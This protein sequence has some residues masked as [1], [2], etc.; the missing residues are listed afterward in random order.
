MDTNLGV[1]NNIFLKK[2]I[3]NNFFFEFPDGYTSNFKI[4]LLSFTPANLNFNQNKIDFTWLR[5]KLR[6]FVYPFQSLEPSG[7]PNSCPTTFIY[8][9]FEI[10]IYVTKLIGQ[11]G[12][13]LH[14]DRLGHWTTGPLTKCVVNAS[15]KRCTFDEGKLQLFC[16]CHIVVTWTRQ[17]EIQSVSSRE[18][19]DT[20]S[21]RI[22]I[23][24][25]LLTPIACFPYISQCAQCVILPTKQVY[26]IPLGLII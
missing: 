10:Q 15:C 25:I 5:L 24:L 22:L 17:T 9:V 26:K 21:C 20:F 7:I 2:Y 23:L 19:S 3:N 18:N 8:F 16:S 6:A 1:L 11:E 14:C 13:T 12:S 4:V